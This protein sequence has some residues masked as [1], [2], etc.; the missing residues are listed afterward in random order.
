MNDDARKQLRLISNSACHACP[1][2]DTQARNGA[3]VGE[4][5]AMRL[6]AVT[7]PGLPCAVRTSSGR[8]HNQRELNTVPRL[9]LTSCTSM[10]TGEIKSRI[11]L[12]LDTCGAR[13]LER[14]EMLAKP[15]PERPSRLRLNAERNLGSRNTTAEGM[16]DNRSTT[17][18]M[19]SFPLGVP[20]SLATFTIHQNVSM[21]GDT[22]QLVSCCLLVDVV[23]KD[24]AG[25]NHTFL[26]PI[27]YS[28][29]FLVGLPIKT[30]R[31]QHSQELP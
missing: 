23:L 16:H 1:V 18:M 9:E 27:I 20:P 31:R 3:A 12:R 15:L 7:Q 30:S 5:V 2:Y 29:L 28:H 14:R 10:L 19:A 25:F 6:Q 4:T 22:L 26:H 13:H 17:A 8:K 21:S 11:S 24:E